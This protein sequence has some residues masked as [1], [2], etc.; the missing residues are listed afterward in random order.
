MARRTSEKSC[1][2]VGRKEESDQ[3]KSGHKISAEEKGNDQEND[4]HNEQQNSG[5]EVAK[6][7]HCT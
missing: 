2:E 3:E 6:T 7:G 4:H 5:D 1:A